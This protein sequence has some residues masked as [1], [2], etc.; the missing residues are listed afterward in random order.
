MFENKILFVAPLRILKK[1]YKK[2]V[3]F[4][5]ARECSAEVKKKYSDYSSIIEAC[6]I[7]FKL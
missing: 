1:K 3:K 2:K 6:K 5:S 4:V 7:M